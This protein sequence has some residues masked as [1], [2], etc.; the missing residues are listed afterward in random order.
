MPGEP[1][2]V[3]EIRY[4]QKRVR[5]RV[6]LRETKDLLGT[7]GAALYV[8]NL[9]IYFHFHLSEPVTTSKCTNCP[10]SGKKYHFTT[11]GLRLCDIVISCNF[12]ISY[13]FGISFFFP[14]WTKETQ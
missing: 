5:V 9:E 6:W 13:T 14:G 7:V 2:P 4:V 1:H 12:P 3:R 11:T 10:K 8:Y